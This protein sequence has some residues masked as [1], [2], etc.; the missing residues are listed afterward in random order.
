MYWRETL[1]VMATRQRLSGHRNRSDSE[2]YREGFFVQIELVTDLLRLNEFAKSWDTLA[3][4]VNQP[5]AGARIIA[6]W[7][8]HMM[9]SASELRIWIATEG[10]QVIGVL[11]F[12]AESLPRGRERLLPPAAT[13]M[14]GSIPIAKP[15][16]EREVADALV[17]ECISSTPLVGVVGL[18]AMPPS[19]PWTEAFSR[20]LQG[21]EWVALDPIHHRSLYIDLEEGVEE[22]LGRRQSKFKREVRRRARIQEA[23][24]FCLSATTDPSEIIKRLP[25]VQR[26]YT[27]RQQDRGGDGY[28]FDGTMIDAIKEVLALSRPGH[29][30]LVTIERGDLV[31]AMQLELF[32]GHRRSAWMMGFDSSWGQLGPGKAVLAGAIAASSDDGSKIF[33][34]GGGDESYKNDFVDGGYPLEDWLWCSPRMARLLRPRPVD[35]SNTEEPSGTSRPIVD[36]S[37]LF[38]A[39]A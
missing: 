1:N 38:P 3:C 15:S 7:A 20:S 23:E 32:V 27:A 9:E 16:S 37:S 18:D 34:L 2:A 8:H 6:A 31:I 4:E 12:V 39:S 24:G 19:S 29:L 35:P 5:R 13:L 10:D 11:P 14:Y 21:P 26:L 25:A 22:W 36:D 17:A 33:D 28:R 30:R